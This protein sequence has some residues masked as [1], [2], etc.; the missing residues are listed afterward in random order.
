MGLIMII[1]VVGEQELGRPQTDFVF[2]VW[3]WI[4][5][6]VSC[7]SSLMDMCLFHVR[8]LMI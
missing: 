3:T 8:C 5:I 1:Q 2:I 4:D 7:R 6:A